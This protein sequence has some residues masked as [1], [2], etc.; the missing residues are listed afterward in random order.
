VG[1]AICVGEKHHDAWCFPT[2]NEVAT[3]LSM[4]VDC[5]YLPSIVN[6]S[7]SFETDSDDD[8]SVF[9]DNFDVED[10]TDPDGVNEEDDNEDEDPAIVMENV[11]ELT[12]VPDGEVPVGNVVELDDHCD[13][14]IDDEQ[15]E[16]EFTT[17]HTFLIWIKTL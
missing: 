7:C 17:K 4:L 5:C 1:K 16:E 11:R 9:S 6:D 3:D 10:H 14:M 12:L 15:E 2:L 13:V 8:T